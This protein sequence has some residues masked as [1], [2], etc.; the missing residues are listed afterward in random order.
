MGNVLSRGRMS[1]RKVL[2]PEDDEN[3]KEKKK[4]YSINHRHSLDEK[5]LPIP[6]QQILDVED[7]ED[8]AT[9]KEVGYRGDDILGP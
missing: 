1:S 5:I 6:A 9:V 3:K 7:E 8:N 4:E 2:T